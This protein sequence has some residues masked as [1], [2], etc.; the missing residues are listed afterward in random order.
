MRTTDRNS[1]N[2]VY[3]CKPLPAVIC[4]IP[5]RACGTPKYGRA[6]TN[7][8]DAVRFA[9]ER[10]VRILAFR[11]PRRWTRGPV[12]TQYIVPEWYVRYCSRFFPG[13]CL[14]APSFESST[15]RILREY[16]DV[17]RAKLIAFDAAVHDLAKTV[18]HYGDVNNILYCAPRVRVAVAVL[19]YCMV[20]RDEKR[21]SSEYRAVQYR[22]MRFQSAISTLENHEHASRT[23]ITRISRL[24]PHPSERIKQTCVA[25]TVYYTRWAQEVG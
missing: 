5:R 20:S 13:S 15:K 14:P 9:A 7:V 3:L 18:R 22:R 4:R 17:S 1:P 21:K 16:F 19:E 24:N 2:T 25:T 12:D 23:T 10:T 8:C 6:R 11:V